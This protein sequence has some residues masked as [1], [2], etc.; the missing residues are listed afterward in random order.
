MSKAAMVSCG[1]LEARDGP[2]WCG[3]CQ[4]A[5]RFVWAGSRAIS[6][7]PG[8]VLGCPV[9][10]QCRD[11]GHGTSGT[12]AL[13]SS[14]CFGIGNC[15][16]AARCSESPSSSGPHGPAEMGRPLT[17][18][19]TRSGVNAATRTSSFSTSR[20]SIFRCL[21]S[22]CRRPRVSIGSPTHVHLLVL[23]RGHEDEGRRRCQRE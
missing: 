16:V 2:L 3:M 19:R 12:T 1:H 7:P 10:R 4:Q 5:P 23:R 20:N 18:G 15:T 13:N 8:D 11:L 22:P 6:R 9:F 17:N 14:C 21:T